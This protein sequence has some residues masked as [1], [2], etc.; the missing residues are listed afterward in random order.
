[1]TQ[2]GYHGLDPQQFQKWALMDAGQRGTWRESFK[3]FGITSYGDSCGCWGNSLPVSL[4]THCENDK[5]K[6]AMTMFTVRVR[7]ERGTSHIIL[8]LGFSQYVRPATYFQLPHSGS[9]QN[10]FKCKLVELHF[11]YLQLKELRLF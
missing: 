4:E 3:L 2:S 1:M 9:Q 11:Y 10:V 8:V 5:T 7:S 6:V